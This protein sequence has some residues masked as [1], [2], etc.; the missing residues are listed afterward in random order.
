MPRRRRQLDSLY[1]EAPSGTLILNVGINAQHGARLIAEGAGDLVAF[2]RDYIANPDLAE[3]I[4]REAPLNEPRPEYFY[5]SSA[6]GYTDY[7]KTVA[8]LPDSGDRRFPITPVLIRS[9]AVNNAS[10]MGLESHLA[11]AAVRG[12]GGGDARLRPD[13]M[14]VSK[15][16]QHMGK[17]LIEHVHVETEK[18]F[19]EV[20]AAFEA[21]VGMIDPAVYERLRNGDDPEAVRARLEGMAGPSGFMLFRASDHGALLRL[22]GQTKKAVQYLLGNPLFA[23]QMTQHD[24]RAGLY[25]PLRVLVYEDEEGKTCVE[26][27]RPSSLFG[28]FG[29]AKVTDVATML[30]QKLGQLVAEA[31]R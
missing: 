30:D 8:K 18:P 1:D 10:F 6:T 14:S 15:Q 25:A 5:G 21:R 19:G 27:D 28:Q 3:R 22:V 23:I 7:P 31:I 24:V 9:V 26:Y 11:N 17:I 13:G 16:E 2:G 29:N 4:R 12:I 20:A